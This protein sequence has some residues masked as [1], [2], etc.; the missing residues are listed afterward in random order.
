MA[1]EAKINGARK[2]SPPP[3]QVTPTVLSRNSQDAHEFDAYNN[4]MKIAPTAPELVSDICDR[5]IVADASE[6]RRSFMLSVFPAVVGP[7]DTKTFS[8]NGRLLP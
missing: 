7:A 5:D 3:V 1:L 4:A 2:R 8:W 6:Y